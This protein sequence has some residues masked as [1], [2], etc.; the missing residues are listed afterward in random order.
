MTAMTAA[1]LPRRYAVTAASHR[2]ARSQR[3]SLHLRRRLAVSLGLA[4]MVLVLTAG[5]G[6]L[7]AQAQLEDPVAGSVV[8]APGETLWDV[9][10]ASAPEGV[11]ARRQLEA[12]RQLNGI[13]GSQVRAWQVV[14]LPAR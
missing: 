13:E 11:D 9:A 7:G 12:I 14:L 5:I 6:G 8:I 4:V 2:P 10:V 3:R 1:D